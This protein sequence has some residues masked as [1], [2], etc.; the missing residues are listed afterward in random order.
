MIIKAKDIQEAYKTYTQYVGEEWLLEKLPLQN[1]KQD[2]DDNLV[3]QYIWKGDTYLETYFGFDMKTQCNY[4]Y[5]S[6]MGD[7]DIAIVKGSDTTCERN[8]S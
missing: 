5:F 4:V 8:L 6:D 1:F 3:I 2:I 7:G